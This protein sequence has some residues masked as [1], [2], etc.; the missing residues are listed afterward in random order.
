MF[1]RFAKHY[2]TDAT[3]LPFEPAQYSRF[4][5]GDGRQ[6]SVFGR[7]LG[8]AFVNTHAACLLQHEEVVLVPSPYDAIPTA[9]YA[10]AQAFLQ[11]VNCFLY[12]RERK[13]LLQS[14][15][16]RYKTYTV[17]Y[18]NLNAEERLQLISSDA[19]HLDRFFLEGRLVLFLDDICITGSHEAVIRRQVEKA[20]I[21]GHFMFLYYAMLQN[22]RIAPDFENYLNYYD[23][24]GVEQI[25][26]LWQQPGYAMN[27]RVIKYILKSE[28]LALH[29]FL[30][31]ANGAQL[32]QLVHYAVGNNY[33]LLDDYRNNLNIIIKFIQ[34]GN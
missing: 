4:K 32:Q 15:I 7:E 2:I 12:Q 22:E 23:M 3:N 18:G 10:M 20:G 11:E 28:P 33:H 6:A 17:D 30:P 1:T 5:F 31:Q 26:M 34:Y 14:K 19:Y 29:T 16:H 24:A 9:S 25:A 21:N 27:T 8:Q 13:T